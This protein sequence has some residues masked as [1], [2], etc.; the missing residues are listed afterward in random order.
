MCKM[1]KTLRAKGLYFV[2]LHFFFNRDC[3]FEV[4]ISTCWKM[5]MIEGTIV[6]FPVDISDFE[7]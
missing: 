5:V 7:K 4:I 3:T 1:A 6:S 2:F